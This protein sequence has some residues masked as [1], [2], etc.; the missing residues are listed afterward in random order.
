MGGCSSQ[1][2]EPKSSSGLLISAWITE[3][4]IMCLLFKQVPLSGEK[5]A[6]PGFVSFYCTLTKNTAV[7]YSFIH[8]SPL[9]GAAEDTPSLELSETQIAIK[10]SHTFDFLFPFFFFW[11]GGGTGT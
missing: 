9:G 5:V 1:R 7:L 2:G 11:R 8:P 4:Q 6:K 3:I 10:S